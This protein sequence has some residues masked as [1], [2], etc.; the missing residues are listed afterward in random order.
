MTELRVDPFQAVAALPGVAAAATHARDAI[1]VLLR[2]PAMRN[3]SGQV[4]ARSVVLG[5]EASV[6]LAELEAAGQDRPRQP[7]GEPSRP[8]ATRAADDGYLQG[9]LRATAAAPELA[10]IWRTTPRQA[11]ARL[12]VLAGR[13]VS[14]EPQ[15][16]GRPRPDADA[17]RLAQLLRLATTSRAPGVVVATLVHAELVTLG[18]FA[19][20]NGV[21]A[22]AAERLVL[23]A[24]GVDPA[25]VSV[26][27]AGH[28]A[29]DEY[30]S[31]L[32]AYGDRPDGVAAWVLHC[33]DAY[34]YGAE[35]SLAELAG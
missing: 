1:D 34:A 4:A 17:A 25:A 20:V 18:P 9:A 15:T 26:P 29:S 14:D 30:R 12:H 7:V 35:R 3:R 19:S 8:R 32:A 24:S 28:A 11:L 31:L 22:R 23:V 5:A 10:A 27:E 13:D 16:L 2:H 21:V 6:R 33:A